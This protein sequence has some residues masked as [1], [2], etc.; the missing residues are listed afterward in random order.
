[1]FAFFFSEIKCGVLAVAFFS[2][3]IILLNCELWSSQFLAF[4]SRRV[5]LAK[6]KFFSDRAKNFFGRVSSNFPTFFFFLPGFLIKSR[7]LFVIFCFHK[8]VGFRSQKFFFSVRAK[9]F[10]GHVSSNFPTFFF[11]L[12][13]FFFFFHYFYYYYSAFYPAS[14]RGVSPPAPYKI[15]KI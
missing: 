14:F 3:S 11:F 7:T 8:P 15:Q 1:M 4:T 13:G 12:L 5:S 10:F 2:A 9:N 6:K